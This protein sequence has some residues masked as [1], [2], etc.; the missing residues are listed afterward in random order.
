MKTPTCISCNTKQCLLDGTVEGTHND[1][2]N[3]GVGFQ[4]DCAM[5]EKKLR[6][7]GM[8]NSRLMPEPG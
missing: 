1:D 3:L 4:C 8:A 7:S 2:C 6:M 5:S